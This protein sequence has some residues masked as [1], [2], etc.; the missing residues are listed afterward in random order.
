MVKEKP[1]PNKEEETMK[2][3]SFIRKSIE[4]FKKKKT[5]K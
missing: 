2:K 5:A 4:K 1:K 3:L